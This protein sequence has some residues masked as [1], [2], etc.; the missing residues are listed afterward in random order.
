MLLTTTDSCADTMVREAL[1]KVQ[2][3]RKPNEGEELIQKPFPD[4]IKDIF[5]EDWLKRHAP[6]SDYKEG[7][8]FT[9]R[10]ETFSIFKH[11][12]A[13]EIKRRYGVEVIVKL[14]NIGDEYI[15]TNSWEWAIVATKRRPTLRELLGAYL[16]HRW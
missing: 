1:K 14:T 7:Y 5:E 6:L 2:R 3:L 15:M 11:D 12:L 16:L 9:L 10:N 8:G 13:L 4:L